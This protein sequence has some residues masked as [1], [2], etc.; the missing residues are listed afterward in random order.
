MTRFV[1]DVGAAL[2]IVE[3]QIEPAS[4]HTLLAPTLL[5]SQALDALYGRVARGELSEKAGRELNARFGKLKI[6]FLGAPCCVSALGRSR[7]RSARPRPSTPSIC[8]DAA[9]GRRARRRGR[10]L[11]GAGREPGRRQ[12]VRRASGDVSRVTRSGTPAA[13]RCAAARARRSRPSRCFPRRTDR[14][15]RGP[16]ALLDSRH[17]R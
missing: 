14:R 9:P 3:E 17:A 2:R 11:G 15:R 1:I 8:A 4:G 13:A 6:R 16:P 12:A 10:R 5:R 7:R